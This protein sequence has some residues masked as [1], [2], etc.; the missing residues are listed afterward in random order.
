MRCS[1][2]Q[3]LRLVKRL[4]AQAA[5]RIKG[6]LGKTW[7]KTAGLNEDDHIFFAKLACS[8]SLARP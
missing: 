4:G 7:V 6:L 2:F 1:D 3:Q 5:L 8:S